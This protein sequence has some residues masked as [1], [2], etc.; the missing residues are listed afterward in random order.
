MLMKNCWINQGFK[1]AVMKILMLISVY[2]MAKDKPFVI[3]PVANDQY[4]RI[5]QDIIQ[6]MNETSDLSWEELVIPQGV[7][8]NYYYQ[9]LNQPDNQGMLF[10]GHRGVKLIS[11]LD[12]DVPVI[13]GAVTY[14]PKHIPAENVMVLSYA[15]SPHQ[16]FH[17]LK[18]ITDRKRVHVVYNPELNQWLIDNAVIA[19]KAIGLELIPHRAS[20]IKEGARVYKKLLSSLEPDQESLWL[21]QDRTVMNT[22]VLLPLILK[23]SWKRKIVVFS[24]RLADVNRGALFGLYP[25]H[26]QMG[27]RLGTLAQEMVKNSHQGKEVLTLENT[28]SALNVR[29]ARHLQLKLKHSDEQQFDLLLPTK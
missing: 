11:E 12:V 8:L 5:F 14:V 3:Y 6:G 4:H 16:L 18:T 20:S 24:S 21:I 1:V 26:Y 23:M 22:N 10:L 29:T 7:S 17:I 13:I 19:A 9:K 25:N 15:P 2:V 27:K 28:K